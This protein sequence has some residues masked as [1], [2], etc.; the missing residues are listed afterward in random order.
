MLATVQAKLVL[1]FGDLIPMAPVHDKSADQDR[2]TVNKQN[3]EPEAKLKRYLWCKEYNWSR[4][5]KYLERLSNPT[6]DEVHDEGG[7]RLGED[8]IP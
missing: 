1:G 2:A 7:L 3:E 6:V 4:L 8:P 5:K